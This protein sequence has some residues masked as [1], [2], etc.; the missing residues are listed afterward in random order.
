MDDSRVTGPAAATIPE[1][2]A[3]VATPPGRGGIGIVR[4]SGPQVPDIASR[5]LGRLPTPR[6]AV[7]T[8]FR[9]AGGEAIDQGVA[10]YFPAPASF[11]GE[12]VL[13]LQGHGGPVVMDLLLG[14]TIELGA[15]QARP[16][17]FSE[18][19]F[20]NG[21]ID[22]AQAEAIAD[23]IDSASTAAARGAMRSLTGHF[24]T[25]VHE[26]VAALIRLRVRVEAN[27]DFSDEPDIETLEHSR[28]GQ[29]LDQLADDLDALFSVARQGRRLAEGLTCVLAG[30][31]N[32]GKSS[33]LNRL[34]ARE[35]AIVTAQAGTTR[36]LLRETV[37]VGGMP[38]H[39][40]DTA[41]LRDDP[42]MVEAEGI[43][44]ALAA[45][46]SAERVLWVVD[47][48]A[49]SASSFRSVSRS[50][51]DIE[52]M[53]PLTVL[54]NKCD[55][56]GDPMGA[57]ASAGG[58]CINLSAR[59]GEGIDALRRHLADV[60]RLDHQVEGVFSARR[61]HLAALEEARAALARAADVQNRT[62]AL[63]LLAEELRMAQ[64]ALDE[65]TGR[66]G[67]DDLLGRIFS[68][69]CIGK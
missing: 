16:G 13:E 22:L 2:I 60:A 56:S 26:L 54:R 25:R 23:L 44:R 68:T 21:R 4:V 31:P 59:T 65:I 51:P 42:D 57:V 46:R 15:R 55:L 41:G 8:A 6:H 48:S 28:I 50:M 36:D 38:V 66:F 9:D 47:A 29:E 17:E 11:T 20:L 24:S 14:R 33:L 30:A 62:G 43:R 35:T 69:F 12:H 67:S 34:S 40:L 27:I 53:P 19:A 37:L 45:M 63:E 61:R 52:G 49:E 32:V 3:A 58:A 39:L 7:F 18:R 64:Q 1:T 5:I 10:L